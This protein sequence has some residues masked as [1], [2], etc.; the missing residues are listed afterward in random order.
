MAI[1][2][3]TSQ[4]NR[5]SPLKTRLLGQMKRRMF[6]RQR[7]LCKCPSLLGHLVEDGNPIPDLELG[8]FGPNGMNVARRVV[9]AVSRD[10]QL[11]KFPVLGVGAGV[12]YLD[13][14]LVVIWCAV[15]RG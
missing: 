9:A 2:Q 13:D 12:D 11:G 14:E 6:P 4:R 15:R 3:L 1:P 8:H 5:R 10:A 7:I